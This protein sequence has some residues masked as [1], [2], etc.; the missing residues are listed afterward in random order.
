[1]TVI[2]CEVLKRGERRSYAW[3]RTR[4]DKCAKRVWV[5]VSDLKEAPKS[6]L[7]CQTC[8]ELEGIKDKPTPYPK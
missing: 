5:K 1:L 7:L 2:V 6:R 3:T 8:A 4:C